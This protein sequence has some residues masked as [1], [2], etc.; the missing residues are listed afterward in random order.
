MFY[1]VLTPERLPECEYEGHFFRRYYYK[2]KEICSRP[3]NNVFWMVLMEVIPH[4]P[5][6]SELIIGFVFLLFLDAVHD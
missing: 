1:P 3:E 6:E 4:F 2:N 5:E